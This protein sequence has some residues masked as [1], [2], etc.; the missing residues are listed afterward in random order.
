[1]GHDWLKHSLRTVWELDECVLD[2]C[3][4][5]VLLRSV[6]VAGGQTVT[7]V[8]SSGYSARLSRSREL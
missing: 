7:S 3:S 2:T 4:V 5:P 6:E 1:M 8:A